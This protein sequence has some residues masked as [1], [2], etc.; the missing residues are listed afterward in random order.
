MATPS[1]VLQPLVPVLGGI[2]VLALNFWV[3][4]PFTRGVFSESTSNVLYLLLRLVTFAAVG[5]WLRV[6]TTRRPIQIMSLVTIC[7]FFDQVVFKLGLLRD[8]SRT[9][10]M[11]GVEI[12]VSL[13]M[14]YLLFLPLVLVLAYVGTE[15]GSRIKKK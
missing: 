13:M 2:V 7:A 14:S 11:Q 8:P 9:G 1:R 12:W 6:T 10:G 5:A 4:A 3:I 15:V